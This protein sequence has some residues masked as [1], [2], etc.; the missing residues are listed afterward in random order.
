M[1]VTVKLV[2]IFGT[3]DNCSAKHTTK[4]SVVKMSVF[5]HLKV[6]CSEILCVG[7]SSP[8]NLILLPDFLYVVWVKCYLHVNTNVEISC[9][10]RNN[11]GI[12]NCIKILAVK[13]NSKGLKCL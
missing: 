3:K 13:P 2:K 7:F 8:K 1:A 4:Y 12:I 10:N 11:L 6:N 9:L 5:F